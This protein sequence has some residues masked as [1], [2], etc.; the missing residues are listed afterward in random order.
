MS[1]ANVDCSPAS[2]SPRE[3]TA[4]DSI[5]WDDGRFRIKGGRTYYEAVI[6]NCGTRGDQVKL[7]KLEVV[8]TGNGP[9]LKEVRRYVDPDT[10]LVF[11]ENANCDGTP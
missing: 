2:C 9:R 5:G 8:E 6:F 4:W 3:A 7:A 10:I 11:E 1:V